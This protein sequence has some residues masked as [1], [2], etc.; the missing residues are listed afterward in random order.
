[1]HRV[2]EVL[3][4]RLETNG[5]FQRQIRSTLQP[6]VRHNREWQP[7]FHQMGLKK[8]PKNTPMGYICHMQPQC[9]ST[10]ILIF[11]REGTNLPGQNTS[12]KRSLRLL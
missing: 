10:L 6:S 7:R 12:A 1:M 4:N 11:A 9:S 5:V 8:Q 3:L 2:H